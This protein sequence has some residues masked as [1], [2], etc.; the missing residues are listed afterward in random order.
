MNK[1]NLEEKLTWVAL[2][3]ASL[4][5]EE[6]DFLKRDP[7]LQEI[8]LQNQELLSQLKALSLEDPG[9]LF[10]RKQLK[11][12]QDLLQKEK[13]TS[14]FSW[15][16]LAVAAVLLLCIGLFRLNPWDHH[17]GASQAK[18]EVQEL[19]RTLVELSPSEE[20]SLLG[21]ALPSGEDPWMDLES[22]DQEEL[23]ILIKSL[24]KVEERA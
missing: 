5:S 12:I 17:S 2:G 11:S 18:L 13:K 15:N 19:E 16:W 9:E 14:Y 3:E 21:L 10:F 6:E 8:F 1:D 4:S 24:E 23:K 20:D 22:L 7:E